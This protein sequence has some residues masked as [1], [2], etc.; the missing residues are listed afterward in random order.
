[1]NVAREE[2]APGQPVG[3]AEPVGQFVHHVHSAVSPRMRSWESPVRE[4]FAWSRSPSRV[5]QP[6]A[7]ILKATRVNKEAD[8]WAVDDLRQAVHTGLGGGNYTM[9]FLWIKFWSN[10]GAA[11]MAELDAFSQGLKPLSDDDSV[12]LGFVVAE[13]HGP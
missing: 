7:R 10:G 13:L 9:L 6:A 11:C 12:V 2:K 1:M 8:A 3:N 4:P 5:R